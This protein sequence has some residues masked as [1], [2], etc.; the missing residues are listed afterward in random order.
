MAIVY[1]PNFKKSQ[2]ETDP[3]TMARIS[4]QNTI[5]HLF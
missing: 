4:Y 3:E 2:N 1:T 5:H